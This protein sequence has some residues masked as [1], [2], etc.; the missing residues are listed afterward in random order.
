MISKDKKRIKITL[1]HDTL[2]T[3]E[4]LKP[5]LNLKTKSDIVDYAIFALAMA[6]IEHTANKIKEGENN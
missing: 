1:K 5:L 2:E 4:K 6:V 3:I